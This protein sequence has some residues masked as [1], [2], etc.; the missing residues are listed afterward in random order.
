[1]LSERG[2]E[3]SDGNGDNK[4]R[5]EP[6]HDAVPEHDP[7]ARV[8]EAIQNRHDDDDHKRG[9]ESF[10]EGN[11]EGSCHDCHHKKRAWRTMTKSV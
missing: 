2:K 7:Q 10:T 1:M 6:H 8:P 9:F 3:P 5:A 11:E 4:T